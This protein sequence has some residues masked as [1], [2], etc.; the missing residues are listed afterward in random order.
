MKWRQHW[1]ADNLCNWDIPEVMQNYLPHGLSGFDK[2]GA[3][4]KISF[5]TVKLRIVNLIIA[6]NCCYVYG[7][8]LH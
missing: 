8:T 1:D 5:V 2:D 7:I 6:L 3:P 4:G